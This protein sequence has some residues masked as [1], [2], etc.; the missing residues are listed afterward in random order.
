MGWEICRETGELSLVQAELTFPDRCMCAVI[1]GDHNCWR[2]SRRLHRKEGALKKGHP[3]Q[4]L[5]R[6]SERAGNQGVILF[7]P[8][9]FVAGKQ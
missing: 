2:V 7:F 3:C 6:T 5:Y 9:W 1:C 8:V 4:M